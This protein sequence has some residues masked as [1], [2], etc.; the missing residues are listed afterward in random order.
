MG[1]FAENIK[2][3]TKSQRIGPV[4]PMLR[5]A[6]RP[7]MK[8]GARLASVCLWVLPVWAVGASLDG[9]WQGTLSC[10][11]SL[12]NQNPVYSTSIH[13]D[14]VGM[15]GKGQK[16]D[17]QTT[18][19]FDLQV[20]P[21]NK[22]QMQSVGRR[23]SEAAPRWFTRMEGEIVGDAI[24]LTGRMLGSDGATLVRA[25]CSAHLARGSSDVK[26]DDLA[27]LHEQRTAEVLR[28]MVASGSALTLA[29]PRPNE[30][31]SAEPVRP[32]AGPD[33]RGFRIRE[34]PPSAK[35]LTFKEMQAGPGGLPLGKAGAIY[36][37]EDW[38]TGD[39]QSWHYRSAARASVAPVAVRP[40]RAE[41][42]KVIDQAQ[43]LMR[44]VESRAMV[45]IADGAIVD[46]I[47]TGGIQFNTRLLSASMG[48]TVAALAAGKAVCAGH[49]SMDQRVDSL[50][51]G[52]VGK[53]LGA[54]TLRDV[55]MMASGTTEPSQG[56][57]VGTLPQEVRHYLE[58]P[59]NLEQLLETPRQ[60]TAQRG[61]FSKLKPGERF[62]YKSRDPHVVAMMIERAVG[63]PATRWVDEQLLRA[64][65]AE[66]PVILGTDRSGYFHGAA[67]VVRMA[68]I[69][70]IRFAMYV[71]QQ[72]RGDTCFARFIRD[73]G[74]TQIRAPGV[75]NSIGGY[76]YLTWTDNALAPNSFWAAGY[77]GQRIAWSTDPTNQRV[78][79][80][81]SNSADRHVDQIY[82]IAR[83]WLALGS[84]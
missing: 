36:L 67:G 73:L 3:T 81:F 14:V 38:L 44:R 15:T 12:L 10:S 50:L 54:A 61:V 13:I 72:R 68:L 60:S 39:G 66:H 8:H 45:L 82:P 59:G 49:L 31:A 37:P 18:E 11:Q 53:D 20:M 35:P 34:V 48:K 23:M 28:D 83:A 80:L 51:P 64:F 69:D 42:A 29:P 46:V 55:L 70:W 76:G 17:A 43:A 57:Y 84:R 79:V 63:M 25:N 62:S 71:D 65:N 30:P 56:D 2:M 58:G 26:D 40:P 75:M 19:S 22:M 16:K 77:G 7:I 41:E 9:R 1:S 4:K 33:H 47:T 6:L 74:T 27:A 78:F 24:K 52:L 32:A 21:S 5:M